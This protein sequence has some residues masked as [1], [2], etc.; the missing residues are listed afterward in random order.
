MPFFQEVLVLLWCALRVKAAC[1]NETVSVCVAIQNGSETECQHHYPIVYKLS[2]L[3]ANET[4]CK[5]VRIHL[6][7]GTHILDRDLFLSNSVQETEIHGAPH[8]PPSIIECRN[9]SGIRFSENESVNEILISNI[10]FLHCES[11]A[12]HFKNA[13]YTLSGV[14]VEKTDGTGLF[15]EN[16]TQQIIFNCTFS[17]NKLSISLD[18]FSNKSSNIHIEYSTFTMSHIGAKIRCYGS[19]VNVI[20]RNSTF[21]HNRQTGLYLQNVSYAE[22]T[23]CL[24]GNNMGNAI[25]I[26]VGHRTVIS[27][28]YFSNNSGAITLKGRNTLIN[29]FRVSN[30]SFTNHTGSGVIMAKTKDIHML[31]ESSSFQG[32]KGPLNCSILDIQLMALVVLSD[33]DIADNNC[34]GINI[35]GAHITIKNSVNLIRNHG[36]L[37][38]GLYIKYFFELYLSKSSKLS[39]INNTAD[40]YGGGIYYGARDS[41]NICFFRV[42]GESISDLLV[43]SGN[44]AGEG[45]DAMFG[46]HLTG[47]YTT[48]DG[49][50]TFFSKCSQNN[51]F[52]DLVSSIN[53]VSQSTF[54]DK[55]RRVMFCTN[56]SE[57]TST[58]GPFCNDS[59]SIRH[60]YRGQVFTVS[61]MVAENCC[62]PS[63]GLIEA[64]VKS[65]EES[66]LHF[67]HD[68]IQRG[69]KYCHNFSYVLVGGLKQQT[70]PIEFKH[71]A[72]SVFLT[73]YLEECPIGYEINTESEECNCKV[74]LKAYKIECNPSNVSLKIPGHTWVSVDRELV[75][76]NG[77]QY[78]KS[79]EVELIITKDSN[80]LCTANR[81]GVMCGACVAEY[82]L[83]LG[84]YEC[85]DCSDSTYK[86]VL[87]L[88]A[89]AVIG[90]ALVLLLLG[91]NL[92]VSTG[93]IN[94]LI[95]YSNIVYLNSDALLPTT[96]EGNST[97]LQNTV[98]IL[99]TFQAWMN[100]DFGIVTCFFDGYDTYRS[101][102]MEFVFPLYIWLLILIIVLA[103][104]YS[105]R[106]SKITTSNTVSVLA[107]LLLL[108]YV[109]LLKT[110]I[111]VFSFVELYSLD[112]ASVYYYA[113]KQD[114]NIPYLSFQLHLPLLVMSLLIV[115]IYVI[116]FTLLILLG[117]LLQAKS[118]HRVLRWINKLKPFLDAFYGPYTSRYRYWPGVL[119]LSRLLVTSVASYSPIKLLTV[120]LMA[121]VLLVLWMVIGKINAVSLNQKTLLNYLELFLLLNLTVFVIISASG[122][123]QISQQGLAVAMVGSVMALSCV[124]LGYQIFLT[125]S[126][127]KAVHKII[128]NIAKRKP[129]GESRNPTEKVQDI[130]TNTTQSLVEITTS[131]DQLREPLLTSDIQEL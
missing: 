55:Q 11:P 51:T 104:R 84:G 63:V 76:H 50:E 44:R 47:C 126:K 2:D 93:M 90:I 52:W 26:R 59:N 25:Q 102:W 110:S 69:R 79:E 86:G 108:S 117:P 34:T 30:C 75:V 112:D 80:L 21:S 42:E 57:D 96:R 68:A 13:M 77:C 20:L 89:F 87:L 107:T 100:L 8:G 92:T 128:N 24:L 67:K 28:V 3:T 119:L 129:P 7:S 98:R 88:I 41:N 14:T 18:H 31:L 43:F 17:N 4:G 118:H 56:T 70:A 83:Q 81:A 48:V 49:N 15:G 130:S 5:I 115:L 38:G 9:N 39:L 131:N 36:L 19:T 29:Q 125:F 32:N 116:P 111:E 62:F 124:I 53:V 101:T 97:H 65:D 114:A 16:C 105:K 121:P 74:K 54:V 22:I 106:I 103:S 73:V 123:S 71:D 10:R 23:S 46:G 12:L 60:V 6:T 45:G 40:A 61:L 35:T 82:S 58:S 127:C 33:V 94:G 122:L 66:T 99:S 78:C 27:N 120:S 1:S 85:A 64:I 37:G 109:K 95:F 72:S 113:W 91:L